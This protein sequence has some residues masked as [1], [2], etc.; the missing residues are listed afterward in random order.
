MGLEKVD[1][2]F[3]RKDSVSDFE[4]KISV[5]NFLRAAFRSFDEYMVFS[6]AK[7]RSVCYTFLY[8][9]KSTNRSSG[10]RDSRT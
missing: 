4:V 2:I 10:V 8:A 9:N 5:F 7:T 3:F 6:I 1:S